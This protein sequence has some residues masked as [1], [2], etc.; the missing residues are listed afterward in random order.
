MERQRK[1]QH[2]E[3]IMKKSAKDL[4]QAL[5]HCRINKYFIHTEIGEMRVT[6]TCLH[7]GRAGEVL[8]KNGKEVVAVVFNNGGFISLDETPV[9]EC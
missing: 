6:G 5:A 9:L 4:V 7:E 8:I 1:N 2:G 3:K